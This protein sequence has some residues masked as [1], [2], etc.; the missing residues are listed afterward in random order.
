MNIDNMQLSAREFEI[1]E[2]IALGASKKEVANNIN[3]STY[4]VETTIKNVYDK[5]GI[6]KLSDLVL[7]YCGEMFNIATLIDDRK[8]QILATLLLLIICIHGYDQSQFRIRRY[9]RYREIECSIPVNYYSE[10]I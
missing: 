8:R 6:N 9:R 5:L 2:Q 10:A 7:W 3:R 1:A 4:T